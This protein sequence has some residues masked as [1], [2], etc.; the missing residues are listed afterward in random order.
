VVI[1]SADATSGH[2]QRLVNA[3]ASAYLTKPIDVA[4]LRKLF[5]TLPERTRSERATSERATSKRTTSE[6]TSA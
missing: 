5:D 4:E 3:G 2:V 6:W 1:V